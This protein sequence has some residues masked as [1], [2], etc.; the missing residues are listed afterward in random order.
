MTG[1]RISIFGVAALTAIAGS[2]FGQ[3]SI[4]PDVIAGSITGPQKWGTIGGV[5]SYSIGTESCNI[6]DEDLLWDDEL[7]DGTPANL[8]PLMGQ[9]IFRLKDGRFE[10]LGQSWLKHAFLALN[11]SGLCSNNCQPSSLGSNG[12]G[13]G[14]NDPY[15]AGLNGSQTGL[16][17]K[18]EVN[19]VKGEYP[20]PFTGDGQSVPAGAMRTEL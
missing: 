15:S 13:P 12:L 6:G 20:W 14:C 9:N 19:P 1:N 11:L 4:G 18:F 3:G 5:T 2:A 16:G 7:N 17:P 10:Q 8:H